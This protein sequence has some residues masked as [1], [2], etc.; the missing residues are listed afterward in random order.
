M[1]GFIDG[2]LT[3]R[4]WEAG[5]E[6]PAAACPPRRGR[7]GWRAGPGK[8]AAARAAD[9]AASASSAARHRGAKGAGGA[10]LSPSLSASG[11]ARRRGAGSALRGRRPAMRVLGPK[12]HQ[13][14]WEGGSR[15][16]AIWARAL[17]PLVAARYCATHPTP[18]RARRQIRRS[19]HS[20]P[21]CVVAGAMG[22]G[23]RDA[24][25]ACCRRAAR[26]G[27]I[28][29][30]T[31]ALAAGAHLL[32]YGGFVAARLPL[33][34][35]RTQSALALAAA[36]VCL[37]GAAAVAALRRWAPAAAA[38]ADPFLPFTAVPGSAPRR[39][40]GVDDDCDDDA[41]GGAG[42]GA[43]GPAPPGGGG[44]LAAVAPRRRDAT[45]ADTALVAALALLWHVAM[46]APIVTLVFETRWTLG[47]QTVFFGVAVCA[48][49]ALAFASARV[50]ARSGLAPGDVPARRRRGAA[51]DGGDGGAPATG[52]AM[53]GP[54][55]L[56]RR[57]GAAGGGGGASG[58]GAAGG[59]PAGAP[60]AAVSSLALLPWP[61]AYHGITALLFLAL[62]VD[63]G[64]GIHLNPFA[65]D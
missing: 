12:G 31:S 2:C 38:A 42:G 24:R 48:G 18:A 54:E 34:P 65:R 37:A 55:T 64:G 39:C 63:R 14:L 43:G 16:R 13:A 36:A 40:G 47:A 46:A 45:T 19:I 30:A 9:A 21:G 28:A 53:A 57:A 23:A 15:T 62:H 59:G 35:R 51:D 7:P 5:R 3:S 25:A 4:A 49:A 44:W 8:A 60:A 32:G 6:P 58:G 1:P 33:D 11:P 56:R 27:G 22:G 29:V 20:A 41:C 52:A 26:R 61:L 50:V 10:G 17:A